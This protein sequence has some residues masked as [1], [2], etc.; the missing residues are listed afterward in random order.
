MA[1]PVTFGNLTSA[2]FSQ[3]DQN[4]AALGAICVIPCSVAGTNTIT[5]TPLANTP[6][7]ASYQQT[8][9]F[10]G[11]AA[12]TNTTAVT[13]T[14]GAIGTYNV[15]RDTFTAPTALV[16]GE[17]QAGSLILMAYD[18]ALNTG[19]GGWHLI[20]PLNNQ[21]ATYGLRVTD[22]PTFNAVSTTSGVTIGSTLNVGTTASITGA[23]N[24]GATATFV[25]AITGAGHVNSAGTTFSGQATG[26]STFLGTLTNAPKAGAPDFWLPITV[27]GT[28]GWIPWWHV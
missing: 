6:T 15:Y 2:A 23:V 20:N 10:V 3:I 12:G 8:G 14:V 21:A 27:Y 1:L 11:V 7:V 19:A 16:G 28:A 26:S 13:M 25:G 18:S 24:C 22:S 9:I 5:M 17:I 4:C